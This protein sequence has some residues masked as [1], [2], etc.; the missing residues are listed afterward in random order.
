MIMETFTRRQQKT[1]SHKRPV[2][3][4]EEFLEMTTALCQMDEAT[5]AGLETR[6]TKHAQCK[7][8]L[9]TDNSRVAQY[10]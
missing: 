4:K 2:C 6:A 10:L 8:L 3:R 5:R 9:S 7:Q 1:L